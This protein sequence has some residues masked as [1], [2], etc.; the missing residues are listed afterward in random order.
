MYHTEKEQ[1]FI[2]QNY[3]FR[4]YSKYQK[5]RQEFHSN[6]NNFPFFVF[7]NDR[8]TKN[9]AK[10]NPIILEA[11]SDENFNEI[12]NDTYRNVRK[13]ANESVFEYATNQIRIFDKK[14][15]FNKICTTYQ[16]MK[17]FGKWEWLL[18][19]KL[20]I[21]KYEAFNVSYTLSDFGVF[22]K[23]VSD[24]LNIFIKDS[25]SWQKFNS[26][27]KREKEVLKL[28]T[29]GNTNRDIAEM[30]FVSE[31]TIRTQREKIRYK[32]DASNLFEMIK[33]SQAFE[34]IDAF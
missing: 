27:T 31:H 2:N 24:Q 25:N 11:Y 17:I 18:V 23:K 33:F 21:D 19:N 7:T 20:L 22:G 32:L 16:Y 15:E 10:V 30:Q 5:N 34:L 28:I 13:I 8:N 4:A 26:L 1:F 6:F 29:N 3:I 9:Y 12:K 14:N